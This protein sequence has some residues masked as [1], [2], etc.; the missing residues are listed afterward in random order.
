MPIALRDQVFHLW[1]ITNGNLAADSQVKIIAG[2]NYDGVKSCFDFISN[3][4]QK[5]NDIKEQRRKDKT[6]AAKHVWHVQ[7]DIKNFLNK[8]K[9]SLSKKYI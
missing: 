9:I 2:A 4:F 1:S 6:D 8:I 5:V 7:V 3:S